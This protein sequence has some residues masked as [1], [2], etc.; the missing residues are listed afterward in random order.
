MFSNLRKHVH[1]HAAKPAADDDN[2]RFEKIDDIAEPNR[3]A[4]CDFGEHFFC[5]GIASVCRFDDML[6]FHIGNFAS[7]EFQEWRAFRGFVSEA[8]LRVA[9]YR[10]SRYVHFR[11]AE[12]SA[13][14]SRA[15]KIDGDMAAFAGGSATT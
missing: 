3:Q 15:V 1:H 8:L 5:Q 4:F 13:A 9:R 7:G 12:F 6:S 11:A 10:G 2:L 14:T